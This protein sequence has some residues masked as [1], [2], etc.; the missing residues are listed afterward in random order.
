MLFKRITIESCHEGINNA[1]GA[2]NMPKKE[3]M[4]KR[5]RTMRMTH[6]TQ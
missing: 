5:K 1:N 3:Q 6:I 4:C 2:N